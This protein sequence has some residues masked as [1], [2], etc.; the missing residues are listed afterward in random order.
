MRYIDNSHGDPRDKALVPWLRNVLTEDVVGIRWQSGFF[1]AGVLGLFSPTFRLLSHENLDAVVLVGSNDGE[2]RVSAV[3]A[4]V[5]ILGLPRPNALL[6]VVS[7]A[8]GFYHPKTIHL[9]YRN[10]RQVAYVG[11]SNLTSRGIDGLNI[12]AGIVLDTDDGDPAD[13]LSSI[14]DAAAQWFAVRPEGLF[15]VQN[16]ADVDQLQERGILTIKPVA[17]P[18]PG[19]GGQPGGGKL[20]RRRRRH[21]LPPILDP[22]RDD[23]DEQ[24]EESEVEN[25]VLIAELAGPGRWG[26]AVFPKRFVDDFFQVQP[27]TDDRLHLRPVTDAGEVGQ[28]VA[29]PCGYKGS[30]NWYYELGLAA[31]IHA[32]PPEPLKPIGVFHRIAHQT[33]RYTILMPGGESYRVVADCLREN[34]PEDQGNELSRTIVPLHVLEAAWPNNRFFGD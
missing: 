34:R 6:G 29:V 1:Q 25:L 17:R 32:Y 18:A 5:D 19:D 15:E 22:G 9:C 26:Q 2:T 11:S 7:Y 30:R 16:H 21:R 12:E 24:I 10:G 3:R 33:C 23:D 13:L 8:D 20:P 27:G 31:T 4:L 28:E 14:S